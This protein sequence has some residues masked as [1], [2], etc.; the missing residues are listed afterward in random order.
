MSDFQNTLEREFLDGLN[1][2]QTEAVRHGDGPLLILAGAGSGKTRVITHRIAYLCRVKGVNP[3]R[4]AAVTFTN[5]AAQEMRTRLEA[6]IGPMADRVHIRTFHSL[7]LYIIR[8]HYS[9]LDLKSG[10]SIYDSAAQKSLVKTILKEKKI[11]KDFMR[12]EAVLSRMEGYRDRLLSPDELPRATD[13]YEEAAQQVYREYKLRMRQNHAVDFSDLLYESVRLLQTNEEIR[14]HYQDFWQHFLIDEY[15]DTNHGQY[16][17]GKIIAE[18][19]RNIVVVGD[20]DQAIYSWR[21]ADIT[22]ILSFE[23]DYPEAKILKLEENYRS[24]PIILKAASRVIANNKQRREKTLFTSRDSG[25]DLRYHIYD[26]EFEEAEAVISRIQTLRSQGRKLSDFAIFYRTNA[27]SR[28]F[29]QVLNQQ[30]LPYVLYGG[31]RFFDRKEVKDILAYLNVIVNPEDAISL[32]RIINVPARSVG[33]RSV[34]KL[35]AFAYQ[36]GLSL[37]EAMGRASELPRFRPASTLEELFHQFEQWR[38]MAQSQLPS[39]VA[40]SVYEASGLKEFFSQDS[41]PEAVSRLENVSELISSVQDYEQREENPDLSGFLQNVTLLTSETNPNTPEDRSQCIHLM[42]LH[43]AK[44]LEFPVVFLTGMEEGL[45]PHQLSLDEGNIEEERRLVYVG[46]T[47]AREELYVSHS[48]FRRMGGSMQPR[49]PS[50]FIEEIGLESSGRVSASLGPGSARAG[51]ARVRPPERGLRNASYEQG[52]RV[53]HSKY[54]TGEIVVTESTVAGQKIQIRF[55]DGSTK[56]FLS[57]YTPL[58][59]LED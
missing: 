19:H 12:P 55:S 28:V 40:Q 8:N 57:N 54:G 27:Q 39:L 33:D 32:E 16:I 23:S 29:E 41:D 48:R 45:L 15:Q 21:G 53:K 18:K 11:A 52:Q 46:I 26:S 13:P 24:T 25:E 47:R 42:T 38:A 34:E 49:M 22:N 1:Q 31:F 36:N 51:G 30:S 50:R 58:E 56:L 3:Y 17:L 20:D 43:N 37:Y 9:L 10:F 6:L 5:K 4:I 14:N 44:G 59:I 35:Q 7:G 2:V